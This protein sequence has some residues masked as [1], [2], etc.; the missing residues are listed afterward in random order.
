MPAGAVEA[1]SVGCVE[2]S[3]VWRTGDSTDWLYY[4]GSGVVAG[5]EL[6]HSGEL[7]AWVVP[8]PSLPLNNAVLSAI[9]FPLNSAGIHFSLRKWRAH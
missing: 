2:L 8:G 6:L 7:A 1:S 3:S 4:G 9:Q 5:I